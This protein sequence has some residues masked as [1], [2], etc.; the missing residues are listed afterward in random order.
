MD[1][2]PES[3]TAPVTW[4][5][6]LRCLET[7]CRAE[8]D[9]VN[10]ALFRADKYRRGA[11]LEPMAAPRRELL[12][13]SYYVLQVLAIRLHV[14]W[15]PPVF[16][17]LPGAL[18]ED[19]ADGV[20]AAVREMRRKLRAVEDSLRDANRLLQAE[21]STGVT[22]L[23]ERRKS[24]LRKRKCAERVL[25]EAADCVAPWQDLVR[26][27]RGDSRCRPDVGPRRSL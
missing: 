11:G 20:L 27:D 7:L 22:G 24:I 25:L 12:A 18:P 16:A 23:L 9:Q 6:R 8:L 2:L 15:T 17:D 5:D 21:E 19:E 14:A 4:M 1:D 13:A 10:D 26:K 3:M